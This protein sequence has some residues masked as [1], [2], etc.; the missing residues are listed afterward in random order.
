[1]IENIIKWIP[2]ATPLSIPR[3]DKFVY[4]LKLNANRYRSQYINDQYLS[5][6][7][8]KLFE[9]ILI[10]IPV[11]KFLTEYTSDYARLSAISD[12]LVRNLAS[13]FDP[14]VNLKNFL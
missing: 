13:G 10:N 9:Q 4:L 11:S 6:N 5:T 12:A 7:C 14:I 8:T 2:Q 1:M 3:W